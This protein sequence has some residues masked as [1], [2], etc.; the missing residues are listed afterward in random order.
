MTWRAFIHMLVSLLGLAGVQAEQLPRVESGVSRRAFLKA[1]GVSAAA[2]AAMEVPFALDEPLD[3]DAA[4]PGGGLDLLQ[5]DIIFKD[6]YG[7]AIVAE[8]NRPSAILQ[9]M[10][11]K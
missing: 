8:L 1:L 10:E 7:P 5:F 6:L 11:S 4:I 2:L 9:F 3:L